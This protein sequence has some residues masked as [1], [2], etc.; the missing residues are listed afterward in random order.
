MI[1]DEKM[2]E[3]FLYS[4]LIRKEIWLDLSKIDILMMAD[5]V[6]NDILKFCPSCG[7]TNENQN[8]FCSGC[9]LNLQKGS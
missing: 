4:D 3:S 5:K 8:K 2:R 7:E 9:G 6:T 1:S